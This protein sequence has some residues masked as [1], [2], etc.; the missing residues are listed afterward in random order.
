MQVLS[1][2]NDN[3]IQY[4]HT[5]IQRILAE[6]IKNMPGGLF[7]IKAADGDY[8]YGKDYTYA[9]FASI[10]YI[11]FGK[12]GILLFNALMFYLMIT[13]G[14]YFL[15]KYNSELVSFIVSTAFF[16]LSLSL[17]FMFWI[18]ADVYNMFLIMMGVFFWLIHYDKKDSKYLLIGSLFFGIAIVAKATNIVVFIPFLLYEACRGRYK[19]LFI[20]IAITAIP[21]AIFY[22]YFI[23][24]TGA[25]SFYGGD[26]YTYENEFPFMNGY[27]SI[28]EAGIKFFSITNENADM[29]INLKNVGI[30]L[31]NLPLYFIGKYTGIIWY[32]PFIIFSLLS[33]FTYV[34]KRKDTLKSITDDKKLLSCSI[35]AYILA[36]TGI[37]AY[38]YGGGS[39]GNRYF[40]IYPLFLF[41]VNKVNIKHF[42]II[43]IIA[44]VFMAPLLPA[45]DDPIENMKNDF[46]YYLLPVEYSQAIWTCGTAY[47]FS[48]FNGA[49]YVCGGNADYVTQGFYINRSADILIL[50]PQKADNI[51]LKIASYTDNEVE[52]TIGNNKSMGEL[53][54]YMMETLVFSSPENVYHDHRYYAYRINV[55][56]RDR[57]LLIPVT[58]K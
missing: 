21:I 24:S 37:I 55:D 23:L 31:Y 40:Y 41:L 26:R 4:T 29:M 1:I 50:T 19:E 52:I 36:L 6:N 32:Y 18:H 33:L 49:I 53:K 12:N 46:P 17:V 11:I 45:N 10:F 20:T 47:N 57:V 54:P 42:F 48:G 44:A 22:G 13:A 16:T 39:L 2:A 28:N 3:D 9:F 27:D 51:E 43:S 35:I 38:N 7:L 25:I 58:I 5:D 8:F 15:R 34:L 30:F 56:V 14:Y